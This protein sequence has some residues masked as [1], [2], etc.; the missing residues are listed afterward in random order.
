MF[1]TDPEYDFWPW[2]WKNNGKE[3]RSLHDLKLAWKT[4]DPYKDHIFDPKK[5]NHTNESGDSLKTKKAKNIECETHYVDTSV[6]VT[7]D[8][9]KDYALKK[10]DQQMLKIVDKNKKVA[11]G[12]SGGIDSTLTLAWLVKNKVDFESFV[13]R[14]DPWRGYISKITESNAIEMTKKLGVNNHVVDFNETE[15]N[16]H[17]MIR[18]YCDADA[19]DIPCISLMTQPPASMYLR[20]RIFDAMIVAPVGTD[21]LLLH[22][23]DSWIRFIPDDMFTFL[24]RTGSLFSYMTDY[25]YKLGYHG[26]EWKDKIDPSSD[27]QL[28]HRWEDDLLF[29]MYK[30][31][32]CS[33]A[34]SQDWF[35]M[36]HKIDNSSCDYNQLQDLMGVRW[37]KKQIADWT[38]EDIL[39]LVKHTG[40]TEN[41]YTPD[42][43]NK[44]YILAQC[45]RIQESYRKSKNVL[46]QVYWRGTIDVIKA[47]NKVSPDVVQSIHAL[48]WLSKNG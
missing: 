34:T 48:N 46:Q 30:K 19:Y 27:R 20:E 37:L 17:A 22:R 36:W 26:A 3:C 44:E 33:P 35:E 45:H 41:Y 25:G 28:I 21:D 7:L 5:Q 32:I 14:G 2:T 16:T 31:R 10:F 23:A 12:L 43:K 11:V 38:T 4:I 8:E 13:V 9:Y 1:I 39:P 47:F 29:Q 15:Y 6:K 24:R 42:Q 18:Q 40:C